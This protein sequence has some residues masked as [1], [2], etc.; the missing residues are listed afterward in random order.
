MVLAVEVIQKRPKVSIRQVTKIYS[1]DCSTFSIC[2]KGITLQRN[3]IPNLY[4]LIDLEE[5]TII[6]HI[7]NLDSRLFPPQLCD[8]ED[9][10]K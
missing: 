3:S 4:K 6:E 10:V 7:L 8:V 5:K 1:I 9:I 2:H